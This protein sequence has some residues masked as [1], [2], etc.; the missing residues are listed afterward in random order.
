MHYSWAVVVVALVAKC[1]SAFPLGRRGFIVADVIN[2]PVDDLVK[3]NYALDT[4]DG[5]KRDLRQS[6]FSRFAEASIS[7]S[8]LHVPIPNSKYVKRVA[9]GELVDHEIVGPGDESADEVEIGEDRLVSKD[10]D[11]DQTGIT[12]SKAAPDEIPPDLLPPA[13]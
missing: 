2:S 4:P 3:R 9:D 13:I 10:P 12:V 5:K 1:I 11:D 6:L 8:D 7:S